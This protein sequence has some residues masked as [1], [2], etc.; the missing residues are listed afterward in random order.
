MC[1][2]RAILPQT[3]KTAGD[4]LWWAS[5]PWPQWAYGDVY[6]VTVGG[7]IFTGAFVLMGVTYFG[8]FTRRWCR[9]F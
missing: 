1:V 2:E 5:A 3:Y 6:P 9:H 8:T 7:R 4:A